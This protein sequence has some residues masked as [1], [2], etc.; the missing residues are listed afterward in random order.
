MQEKVLPIKIYTFDPSVLFHP[1]YPQ[2]PYRGEF[3]LKLDIYYLVFTFFTMSSILSKDTVISFFYN[4]TFSLFFL[5]GFRSFTK[6]SQS[7]GCYLMRENIN[8][9]LSSQSLLLYYFCL[10]FYQCQQLLHK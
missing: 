9:L 6:A 5:Q 1:S 7:F 4:S 2:Y 10:G 3:Y 8:F